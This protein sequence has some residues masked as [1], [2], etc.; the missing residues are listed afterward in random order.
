MKI[1]RHLPNLL[2]SLN[3]T[4]GVLGIINAFV[5]DYTNTIFFILVAGIFDFMDGFLARQLN[6]DGDLGK[7]LDSLADMVTFGVLPAIYFYLLSVSM[8]NP[9][10]INYSTVAIAVFSGIRLAIFNLD[11][12]QAVNFR[13]LPTPANAILI[14]TL[15]QIDLA[16]VPGKIFVP[17]IIFFS[18][19]LLV[20]NVKMLSLKMKTF[21]IKENALLYILVLTVAILV[22]FL[23][24]G[25]LPYLIP[26]YIFLSLVGHITSKL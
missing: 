9:D 20:S 17:V 6:S 24:I 11:D 5:G 3:L 4:V 14:S 22:I 1:L 18:C 21:G 7:Q 25:A 15:G 13:G 8:D 23:G 12:S 2:T 26:C 10:W 16:D 19:F